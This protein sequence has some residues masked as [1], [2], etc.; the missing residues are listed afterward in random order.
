[1][2]ITFTRTS[3]FIYKCWKENFCVIL[4]STG[5]HYSAKNSS[6]LTAIFHLHRTV[7]TLTKSAY[8]RITSNNNS[9][10]SAKN[11]NKISSIQF[12]TSSKRSTDRSKPS[13]NRL[14]G[15]L[16]HSYKAKRGTTASIV[17]PVSRLNEK[18]RVIQRKESDRNR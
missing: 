14:V 2:S 17:E 7:R 16:G 3:T 18:E 9:A 10:K 6:K 4:Q 13:S 5:R 12:H 8:S 1:M 15:C 11:Y